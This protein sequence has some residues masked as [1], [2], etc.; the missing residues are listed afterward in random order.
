MEMGVAVLV[1]ACST[2]KESCT[3]KEARLGSEPLSRF[4]TL[5]PIP[6]RAQ[7]RK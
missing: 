5:A 3:L 4:P 2:L 7:V 1:P 6:R